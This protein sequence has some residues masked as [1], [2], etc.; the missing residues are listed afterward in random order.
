MR[1]IVLK[2]ECFR[3]QSHLSVIDEQDHFV[4]FRVSFLSDLRIA[5]SNP[6]HASVAEP[7]LQYCKM[8]SDF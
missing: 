3:V 7:I 5:E 1:G 2:L 4:N 6:N 8:K